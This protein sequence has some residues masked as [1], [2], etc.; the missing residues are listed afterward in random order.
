MATHFKLIQ[1]IEEEKK[2]FNVLIDC[3]MKHNE[4]CETRLNFVF[5]LAFHNPHHWTTINLSQW[6]RKKI[7]QEILKYY[8]AARST[9]T[10]GNYSKL[11]VRI[12]HFDQIQMKCYVGTDFGTW[13]WWQ[14]TRVDTWNI[15][16]KFFYF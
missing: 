9:F 10:K 4:Q 6:K 13:W 16:L 8:A 14:T 7:S 12:N 2:S 11:C 1:E 3:E 15:K 5:Y